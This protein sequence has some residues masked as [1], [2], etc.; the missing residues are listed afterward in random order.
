MA[1]VISLFIFLVLLLKHYLDSVF[2]VSITSSTHWR[3]VC[4]K[5]L[6]RI[7]NLEFTFSTFSPTFTGLCSEGTAEYH[8]CFTI[9]LCLCRAHLVFQFFFLRFIVGFIYSPV[10]DCSFIVMMLPPPSGFLLRN[11]FI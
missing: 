5:W 9:S 7:L 1:S 3:N 6:V 10:S 4:L 2:L 11:T 8:L